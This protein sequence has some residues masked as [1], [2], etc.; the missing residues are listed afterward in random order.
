VS[1]NR[2]ES[3]GLAADFMLDIGQTAALIA[4]LLRRTPGGKLS[5]SDIGE[6]I[7][8]VADLHASA[9]TL[10]L[11]TCG[12]IEFGWDSGESELVLCATEFDGQTA[13]QSRIV[14]GQRN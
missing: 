4:Q 3:V 5:Q 8:T 9:A 1:E 14:F 12:Q 11:W 13:G 10:E 2:S 7:A 6:A